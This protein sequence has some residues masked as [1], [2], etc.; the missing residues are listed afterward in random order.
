MGYAIRLSADLSG[1]HPSE[2]GVSLS[3]HNT[4]L[5]VRGLRRPQQPAYSN[6]WFMGWAEEESEL[7]YGWFEEQFTIPATGFD[8]AKAERSFK[9]GQLHI[10]IPRARPKTAAPSSSS[11]SAASATATAPAAPSSPPTSS[12]SSSSHPHGNR[13]RRSHHPHHHHNAHYHQP[14]PPQHARY[15]G[16]FHDP[17]AGGFGAPLFG[18]LFGGGRPG[19]V[20]WF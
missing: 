5:T 18:S 17:Y 2:L 20:D 6:S 13:R 8:V 1:V 11:S 9:N 7:P 4:V 14:A 10:L 15:A 3:Q 16:P 12:S 19:L